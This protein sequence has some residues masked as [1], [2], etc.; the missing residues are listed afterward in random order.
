MPLPDCL[1]SCERV[2][3]V[4]LLTSEFWKKV[5]DI[6]RLMREGE[7]QAELCVKPPLLVSI[8]GWRR[9]GPKLWL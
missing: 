4:E 2:A 6:V 7:I 5:D 8:P 9:T 3:L 1:C